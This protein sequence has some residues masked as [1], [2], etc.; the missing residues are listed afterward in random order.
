M[1]MPIRFFAAILA[2]FCLSFPA[3][4]QSGRAE[5]IVLGNNPQLLSCYK[6]D[7]C[8]VVRGVCGE[9]RAVNQT[10]EHKLVD[11][12]NFMRVGVECQSSPDNRNKPN[13]SCSLSGICQLAD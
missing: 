12:I 6:N 4:A 10:N 11:A 1:T 8:V 13:A 5:D 9:W 3:F 2:F 7:E